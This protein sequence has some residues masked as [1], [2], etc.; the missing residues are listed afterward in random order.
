LRVN[1]SPPARISDAQI[2]AQSFR[3]AL[4]LVRLHLE[5]LARPI[6][7][8]VSEEAVRAAHVAN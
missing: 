5:L 1:G 7:E 8:F 6:V 3:D 4:D 2:A